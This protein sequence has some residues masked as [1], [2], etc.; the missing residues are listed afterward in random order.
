MPT[1][2]Q[3]ER[4]DR[5]HEDRAG[6]VA[7][8]DRVDEFRL[9][10]RIEQELEKRGQLH[11]H[12]REVEMRADRVLHPAIGDEDPQR[13]EIRAD[14][15]QPGDGEMTD[16]RQPVPA[17][18]EESDEGGFEEERHQPF[19]RQRRAEYV[20][21]VMR[22]IGP[23]GAELELHGDAGGDAHGEIDAEQR[24]PEPRHRPP[25]PP[26]GHDIDALHD[27][28]EQRQAEGQ[29]DEEEMIERGDGELQPRQL[30]DVEIDH[31]CTRSVAPPFGEPIS[32]ASMAPLSTAT[33][34]AGPKNMA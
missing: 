33:R 25:D 19:D 27:G 28:E 15:D 7:G 2:Q 21:D 20:A 14:G 17:E 29:R 23:V 13:R 34:C 5:E 1:A 31:R 18:E 16:A 26:P 3:I 10:D 6:N 12:R 24:A 9:G 11:P 30:H 32:R 22:V 4:A 8:A